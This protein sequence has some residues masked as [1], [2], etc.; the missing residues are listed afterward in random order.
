MSQEP[1]IKDVFIAVQGLQGTVQGLQGLQ[2]NVK[3]LQG[4]MQELKVTVNDLKND[5]QELKV[6]V[7]GL[8]NDTRELKGDMQDMHE[9]M[10]EF[11]C[12]VDEGF[13]QIR[14]E[15]KEMKGEIA[16]TKGEITGIK[17]TMVTKSYLDE[18]LADYY[19]Y[20]VSMMRREDQK[21]NVF[22][23]VAVDERA[24]GKH[25]A[26]KVKAVKVFPGK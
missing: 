26:Q 16:G 19:G 13:G 25:G 8:K 6:S 10:N 18:K 12:H 17:S 5:T 20:T 14:G 21:L 9:A 4:D 1:T 7:H 22:L 23:E 24:I 11:A 2:G 15:I 3:S